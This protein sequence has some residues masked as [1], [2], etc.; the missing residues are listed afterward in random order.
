MRPIAD[1]L[2]QVITALHKLVYIDQLPSDIMGDSRS[3]LQHYKRHIFGARQSAATIKAEVVKL[4][5][6]SREI[7]K[8]QDTSLLREA[9]EYESK[10]D[11]GRELTYNDLG[12][13]LEEVLLSHNFYNG[14]K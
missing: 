14:M 2:L 6:R 3:V 1:P 13:M 10:V 9:R 11:C 8:V 12:S 4:L 5:S 7:V